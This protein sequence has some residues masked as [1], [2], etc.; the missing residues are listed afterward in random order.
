MTETGGVKAVGKHLEE[1]F[2]I[3]TEFLDYPTGM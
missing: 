2:G 3:K 1:Q